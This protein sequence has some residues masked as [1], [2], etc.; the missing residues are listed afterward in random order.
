MALVV[1][2][3][4]PQTRNNGTKI[5][6]SETTGLYSSPLNIGG[7]DPTDVTNPSVASVTASSIVITKPDTSV[8]TILNP[9]G[10]PTSDTQLEYEIPASTLDS[11]WSK[12]PDGVY[13]I[14]YTVTSTTDYTVTKTFLLSSNVECCVKKLYAKIATVTDCSCDSYVVKNAIYAGALLEGLLAARDCGNTTA[15]TNLLNKLT[16]IC[17][18]ASTS[19]SC[20]CS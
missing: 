1:K 13:T 20:G 19:G 5:Y 6:F 12:F 16:K 14:T 4:S 10:L 18:S 3:S 11:T 2:I 8:T 7:Y 15:I 17:A 9:T